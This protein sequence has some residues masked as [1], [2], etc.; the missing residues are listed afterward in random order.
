MTSI[1]PESGGTILEPT[2]R[3]R[4]RAIQQRLLLLTHAQRCLAVIYPGEPFEEGSDPRQCFVP[5][6]KPMKI[7]LNHMAQ[8]HGGRNCTFPNCSASTQIITHWKNCN[9][10]ECAVCG[11]LRLIPIREVD[12][13]NRR[14]TTQ[15]GQTTFQPVQFVMNTPAVTP[16]N[17]AV[18]NPNVRVANASYAA[19]ATVAQSH[20]TSTQSNITQSQSQGNR[21]GT[22]GNTWHR[23]PVVVNSVSHPQPPMLTPPP[24]ERSFTPPVS[25]NNESGPQTASQVANDWRKLI[26]AHERKVFIERMVVAVFPAANPRA[27]QDYRA[28]YLIRYIEAFEQ[29][30]YSRS[31][32]LADYHYNLARKLV[33]IWK[34]LEARRDKDAGQTQQGTTQSGEL[35]RAPPPEEQSVPGPSAVAT[36]EGHNGPS[37]TLERGVVLQLRQRVRQVNDEEI[38]VVNL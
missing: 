24:S 27:M 15:T 21:Y 30:A 28:R 29:T 7:L 11:P 22:E 6:C 16:Q 33:T 3:Q 8:C 18:T 9:N 23:T 37:I 20:G 12:Q 2:A 38:D 34:G 32:S 35:V 25:R 26:T 19:T 14:N 1:R 31:I 10:S 36:Q 4:N 5:N 13:R 17:R